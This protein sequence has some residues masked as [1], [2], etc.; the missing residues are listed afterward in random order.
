MAYGGYADYIRVDSNFAFKIPDNI[1][2][3]LA[4]P[5]LCAGVTVYTPLRC[6]VKPGDRAGVIGIGGLVHL[7]IHF[8]RALDATPVAF[9]RSANKEKEIRALCAEEFYNLNDPDDQ[10]KA[11]NSV[12]VLLLTADA[13]NMPYNTYLALVKKRGTFIMVGVP[14]TR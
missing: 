14:T 13:T 8:I 11:A 9:S 7:A 5:L 2:P 4:A 1:P 3:A 6:Y 10:E 12:N